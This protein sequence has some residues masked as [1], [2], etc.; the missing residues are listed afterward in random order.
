MLTIEKIKI[1]NFKNRPCGILFVYNQEDYLL[2]QL[3]GRDK[4]CRFWLVALI[5]NENE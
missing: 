3:N 5:K 1:H 2:L 4:R